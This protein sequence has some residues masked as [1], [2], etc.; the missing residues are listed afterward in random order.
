MPSHAPCEL[1]DEMI[2]TLSLDAF[3]ASLAKVHPVSFT[4]TATNYCINHLCTRTA[5]MYIQ[6]F[7]IVG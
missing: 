4:R 6:M 1:D 3:A 5:W 2:D 7:E